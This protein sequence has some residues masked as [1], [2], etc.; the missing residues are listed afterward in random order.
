MIGHVCTYVLGG[1]LGKTLFLVLKQPLFYKKVLL[2]DSRFF[3]WV[4]FLFLF[5]TQILET[6]LGNPVLNPPLSFFIFCFIKFQNLGTTDPTNFKSVKLFFHKVFVQI[7]VA[8]FVFFSHSMCATSPD[9]EKELVRKCG[10]SMRSAKWP[11]APGHMLL[12]GE[13][14]L[15]APLPP[16]LFS[17]LFFF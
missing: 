9:K 8:I 4:L 6:I 12:H 17:F 3:D 15:W 10:S 7:Y 2:V 13:A 14:L 1:C 11:A 16:F 5:L